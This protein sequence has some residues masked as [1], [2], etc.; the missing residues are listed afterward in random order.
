MPRQTLVGVSQAGAAPPP[1]HPL[2]ALLIAQFLGAFND[3]VY[4][5]VVSLLAVQDA[6]KAGS[7]SAAL[8]L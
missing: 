3:N 6:L 4:K 1:S 5:M 8:A 7:G 2:R